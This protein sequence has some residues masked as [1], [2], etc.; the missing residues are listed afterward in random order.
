MPLNHS[1]RV[2]PELQAKLEETDCFKAMRA[3]QSDFGFDH[4]WTVEYARGER[5][6]ME[7]WLFRDKEPGRDAAVIEHIH[8]TV[9]PDRSE[10]TVVVSFLNAGP[11]RV[12]VTRKAHGE[13][14]PN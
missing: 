4:V 1:K 9:Y 11:E 13:R 2:A 6:V 10:E 14:S 7:A 12:R 8:L 3:N 5:G